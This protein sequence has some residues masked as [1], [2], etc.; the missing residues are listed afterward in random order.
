MESKTVAIFLVLIYVVVI[1]VMYVCGL[2][3][4]GGTLAEDKEYL[5]K[6]IV[7]LGNTSKE[8]FVKPEGKRS[9]LINSSIKVRDIL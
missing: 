6:I 3:I 1:C 9:S 2:R 7:S 5:G 4:M 8:L